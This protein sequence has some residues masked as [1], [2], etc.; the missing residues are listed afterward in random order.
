MS[1]KKTVGRKSTG[2]RIKLKLLGCKIAEARG[3]Q[4]PNM[5][6][7]ADQH[8]SFTTAADDPIFVPSREQA[9]LGTVPYVAAHHEQYRTMEQLPDPKPEATATGPEE[10]TG[11]NEPAFGAYCPEKLGFDPT[12]DLNLPGSYDEVV[13]RFNRLQ[14][15]RALE[16]LN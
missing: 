4:E 2:K 12:K 13:K 5:Y 7:Q 10:K 8:L 15:D 3:D 1:G 9:A 11:V 6:H 16:V 14:G